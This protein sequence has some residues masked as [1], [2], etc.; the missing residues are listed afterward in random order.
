MATVGISL[1]PRADGAAAALGTNPRTEN[2]SSSGVS[3]ATTMVAVASDYW[4]IAPLGN[5][6]AV[7]GSAP[8]AVAG[9]GFL[10]LAG[11]PYYFK[12]T[13]G[14]KCAVIDAS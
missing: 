7:F 12:A 11:V 2:K 14:D 8:T 1:A 9:S 13:I 5:V 6:W 10:L 3:V 4:Y